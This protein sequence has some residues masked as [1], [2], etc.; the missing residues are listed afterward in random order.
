MPPRHASD[1]TE[2]GRS[3]HW[4][5]R[6]ALS[7]GPGRMA[8]PVFLL[9]RGFLLPPNGR[10]TSGGSR[11][12]SH[13]HHP[14]ERRHPG[15]DGVRRECGVPF[16]GDRGQTVFAGAW[17]SMELGGFVIGVRRSP[18]GKGFNAALTRRRRSRRSRRKRDRLAFTVNRKIA[19]F[20]TL[21]E[22]L[23]SSADDGWTAFGNSSGQG[24]MAAPQRRRSGTSLPFRPFR[25]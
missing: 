15:R 13:L 10:R 3:F 4:E 18:Q 1:P 2:P 6:I 9:R 14:P 8:S 17:L 22:A 11:A 7:P 20:L 19:D 12:R 5:N 24:K 21:V 16:G 23:W 25:G